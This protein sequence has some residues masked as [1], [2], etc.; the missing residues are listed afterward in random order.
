VFLRGWRWGIVAAGSAVMQAQARIAPRHFAISPRPWPA[1]VPAS[2]PRPCYRAPRC[3]RTSAGSPAG[4]QML[5]PQAVSS[6]APCLLAVIAPT[7]ALLCVPTSAEP[8]SGHSLAVA[9]AR[10]A[11][12]I[13][14]SCPSPTTVD[15]RVGP[16]S[17][18]NSP[19]ESCPSQGVSSQDFRA[20]RQRRLL[21]ASVSTR[22]RQEADLRRDGPAG[23]SQL[24]ATS[25]ETRSRPTAAV[26]GIVQ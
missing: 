22:R 15:G 23:Q 24:G 1:I 25:E 18:S 4:R 6:R 26:A 16:K 5:W 14:A 3:S 11:A 7:A 2:S 21:A 12:E 20:C 19:P 13:P 17:E 9:D 10:L 8:P